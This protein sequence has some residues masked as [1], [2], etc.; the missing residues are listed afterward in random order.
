M[1]ELARAT[2]DAVPTARRV[3]RRSFIIG[4][5]VVAAGGA[6]AGPARGLLPFVGGHESLVRS[7]LA[8]HLG[9]RFVLH[10]DGGDIDLEVA[11]ITE[12]PATTVSFPEGQF[13]VRFRSI[14][15][16]DLPQGT[17]ELSSGAFGGVALF[18]SPVS[19][20]GASVTEFEALFNSPEPEAVT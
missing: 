7:A 3:G 6:L 12:L 11:A 16:V 1:T 5:L 17:Y 4:G 10:R 9:E 2:H 18:L 13:G 14:E 19:E 20:P 15:A 8:A